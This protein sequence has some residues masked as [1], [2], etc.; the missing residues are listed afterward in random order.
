MVGCAVGWFGLL[1]VF[2]RTTLL[3]ITGPTNPPLWL[4]NAL[5]FDWRALQPALWG[6][7]VQQ[8]KQ[9]HKKTSE[10]QADNV[11]LTMEN[12]ALRRD[13]GL[14]QRQGLLPGF[15][16]G[17]AVAASAAATPVLPGVLRGRLPS[18]QLWRSSMGCNHPLQSMASSTSVKL[19]GGSI[20]AS[21]IAAAAVVLWGI[22]WARPC[23]RHHVSK[24]LTAHCVRR[25]VTIECPGVLRSGITIRVPP[26]MNGAEVEIRRSGAPGITAV[27]WRRRFTFPWEE[28]VF[29]CRDEEMQLDNGVLRLVF[30]SEL[31]R[32]RLA[33]LPPPWSPQVFALAECDMPTSKSQSS[34]GC[35]QE[36]L[37][38]RS[39]IHSQPEDECSP[40][41]SANR[42]GQFAATLPGAA[43][44]EK[45]EEQEE[46]QEEEEEEEDEGEKA[47]LMQAKQIRCQP[48]GAESLR[49]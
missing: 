48:I 47:F 19:V 27:V 44:L 40:T 49:D 4:H 31:K 46:E 26:R 29:E 6:F 38:S 12:N 7:A 8:T 14:A 13:L 1:I 5:L 3:Q 32:V 45:E 10:L 36:K 42:T 9:L 22:R 16:L 39:T 25:T 18:R 34:D 2:L 37:S 20:F 35:S 11:H 30:E 21:S 17:M 41:A 43:K 23:L 33:H 24:V 28:G 15:A